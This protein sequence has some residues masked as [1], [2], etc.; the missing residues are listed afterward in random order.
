MSEK[1]DDIS[2]STPIFTTP[3]LMLA[4]S[5]G[6]DPTAQTSAV[7]VKVAQARRF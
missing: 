1:I 3:S 6:C 4:A 7:D 2:V 5:A